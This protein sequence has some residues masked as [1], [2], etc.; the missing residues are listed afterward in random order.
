MR[1]IGMTGLQREGCASLRWTF[2]TK[3]GQLKNLANQDDLCCFYPDYVKKAV[4]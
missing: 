3:Q 2:G 1:F 4:P